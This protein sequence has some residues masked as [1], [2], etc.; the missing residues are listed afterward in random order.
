MPGTGLVAAGVKNAGPRRHIRWNIAVIGIAGVA[1][2]TDVAGIACA[3][4]LSILNET[5]TVS[6]IVPKA[7][8]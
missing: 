7:N 8:I 1:V 6:A 3:R 5:I 4:G 2:C